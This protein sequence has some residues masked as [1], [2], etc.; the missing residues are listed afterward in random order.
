VHACIDI[1]ARR[2]SA[3]SHWN[4]WAAVTSFPRFFLSCCLA[5]NGLFAVNRPGRYNI[6]Q[7]GEKRRRWHVHCG[8]LVALAV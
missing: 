3:R 7:H 5:I 1:A 2:N 6:P 4:Y 8:K